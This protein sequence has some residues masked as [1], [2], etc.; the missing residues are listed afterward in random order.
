MLFHSCIKGF[1][2]PSQEQ[3]MC[4]TSISLTE[5]QV[6]S[7]NEMVRQKIYPCAAEA[8]RAAVGLLEDKHNIHGAPVLKSEPIRQNPAGADPRVAEVPG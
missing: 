6:D 5:R 3:K 8:I 2:M 4:R 7:L 1:T